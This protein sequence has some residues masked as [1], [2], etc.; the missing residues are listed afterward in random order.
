MEQDRMKVEEEIQFEQIP[1]RKANNQKVKFTQK[2]FPNL[3]ARDT[4]FK[5]PPM[6]KNKENKA[7]GGDLESKN[8]LW[9]KDKGDGFYKDKNYV[10][11]IEAYS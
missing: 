10:S 7:I 9:L 5:Q 2:I 1:I 3:A 11:A 8:P 4:F 6:P